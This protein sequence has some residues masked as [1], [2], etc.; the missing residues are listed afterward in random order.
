M[1]GSVKHG[2]GRPPKYGRASRAVSLTL[3]EDVIRRLSAIDADLG[4]AIVTLAER[5]T[6]KRSRAPRPAEIAS[7]GNHA[8]IIVT[9]VKALKRLAGVQLVP[10]GNG[11]AL[12]ALERTH[13]IQQL[14]LEIG[15]VIEH[16]NVPLPDRQALK[17]IADILRR[18]RRSR[19]VSLEERMII[20]LESTRRRRP[21]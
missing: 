1:N 12:I 2:P 8:V 10:V 7:Y 5:S 18:T 15:D 17:A 20:V 16:N 13:S 9:P 11:R 4:R 14:E 21:S 3:P 6:P 19:E